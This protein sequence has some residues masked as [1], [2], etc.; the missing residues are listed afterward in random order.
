VIEADDMA[1]AL[2][3]GTELAGASGSPGAFE[4]RPL[5]YYR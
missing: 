1:G 4:I 3:I 2:A 5:T